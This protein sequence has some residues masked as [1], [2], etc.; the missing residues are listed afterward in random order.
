[1]VR[2]FA[3]QKLNLVSIWVILNRLGVKRAFVSMP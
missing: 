3:E 2:W 1:M